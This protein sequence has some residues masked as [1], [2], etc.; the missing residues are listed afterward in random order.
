MKNLIS[1][2]TLLLFI[3]VQS[4]C[5]LKPFVKYGLNKEGFKKF[6]KKEKLAGNNENPQRAYKIN[7]YD[8]AVELMPEKE[9]ISGN[10]KITFTPSVRQ[11]TF[12]FD[13]QKRMKIESFT[14]N[15][16]DAKL[17]HK[18]DF[19]YLS[20]LTD[21][22]FTSRISIEIHYKGKPVKMLGEGPIQWKK[23]DKGRHWISS[24]TEGVGPHFMM[25]CSILLGKQSDT[26]SISVTVPSSLTVTA[27]GQLL[28]ITKKDNKKTFNH[29][30]TNP[31]NIYNISF[32]AGH[33]VKV[34]KPYIDIKGIERTIECFVMDYS[35][36]IASEYYNQAPLI[37][38][39]FEQ[40]FGEFPWWTDGC[41]FVESTFSAMEH[42]SCIAMGDNYYK[43]WKDTINTTL[44]HELAHEWW[45]NNVTGKDY[46]D[47]WIHEGMA[48]Y[49]EALFLEQFLGK[50]DYSRRIKGMLF[51]TANTIPIHKVCGVV[52]NSWTNGPDQ[53]IYSKGGLMMH[54]LRVL[55]NDDRLFMNALKQIQ[56]D[57]A[58]QNV[59]S[60][61]MV[62]KLNELLLDDY[63]PM[64]NWYLDEA[65]PP[66]L[67]I[68]LDR[69]KGKLQ[70]K[71]AKEIPLMMRQELLLLI[72]DE[73]TRLNPTIQYQTIDVVPGQK[74]NFLIERGIYYQL[75]VLEIKE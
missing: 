15:I 4:S 51:S 44:V 58:K 18:G 72:N 59:S 22:D 36:E 10:M 12:M 75:N 33:F 30:V 8:W 29:L 20:F 42:Q 21:M 23:D 64:L 53:D 1:K 19:L 9:R 48:T 63:S 61:E 54:S 7:R 47:I 11:D 41:R 25:P 55:V 32:N 14:C 67:E 16:A 46:C 31:I 40:L 62:N 6:S 13:L 71:W 74:L 69:T 2:V 37:M 38:K 56:I 68:K 50:E 34:E 70:Y 24:I 60:E 35:E 52:Y 45:G 57:F 26:T 43:D 17:K 66:Q 39:E 28:S 3:L 49:S 65:K 5:Y 73:E 27:N